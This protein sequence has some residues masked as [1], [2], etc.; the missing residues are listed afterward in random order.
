MK[1]RLDKLVVVRGAASRMAAAALA[2]ASSRVAEHI[3]IAARLDQ[4]G[5][6]LTPETGGATGAI[7]GGQLELGERMRS[8]RHLA[9]GRVE[10]ATADRTQ[11]GIARK[12]ARRAL[13]AAVDIRRVERQAVA[14]R[15]AARAV[16]VTG[17]TRT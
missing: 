17:K 14:I 11:A 15:L 1:A 9:Q 12:A 4:A 10:A 5:A 7:L 13:D 8:A 16:P 2:D 6:T 3:D